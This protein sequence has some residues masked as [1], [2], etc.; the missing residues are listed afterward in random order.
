[1][2]QQVSPWFPL[3][4]AWAGGQEL[5]MPSFFRVRLF[6]STVMM[7]AMNQTR[8]L[9]LSAVILETKKT[10]LIQVSYLH[11]SI[12]INQEVII[13]IDQGYIFPYG[14]PDHPASILGIRMLK[15]VA[16]SWV[17][18]DS[19][20]EMIVPILS[21]YLPLFTYSWLIFIVNAGKCSIHGCC[22]VCNIVDIKANK[23][24][25]HNRM[26]ACQ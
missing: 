19:R 11:G 12:Q 4:N 14:N 10:L 8:P 5:L 7:S 15:C 26:K 13:M 21:M 25:R 24:D 18:L 16:Y 1:M 3:S 23:N 22:G 2:I 17:S 20:F 6:R 9:L